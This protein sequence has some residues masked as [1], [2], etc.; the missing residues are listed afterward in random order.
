MSAAYRLLCSSLLLLAACSSEAPPPAA[1]P[2]ALDS[3]TVAELASRLVE[4]MGGRAAVDGAATIVRQGTGTRTRMGQIAATGGDDPMGELAGITETIDLANGRAAMDYDVISGGFM[5]HRTEVLTMHEGQPIG[6]ET[7]PGRPNIAVSPNGIFSWGTQNSPAW[8]LKRNVISIALAAAAAPNEQPAEE[9]IFNGSTSLYGRVGLV[10]G[11]EIGL[12]FDPDTGLL[13]GYTALDTEVLL[14][15]V[16]AEY[17]LADWR[18]AGALVLPHRMTIRKDNAPYS[19]VSYS[20][21]AVNPGGANAVFAIPADAVAQAD[22]VVA[23]AGGW[24]PLQ[25]NN[26]ANGVY[27]AVGYSHHSMVVEFPSFVA[28]IEAPYT[29]AHSQT[30]V[31]L[32]DNEIGKPVRYVVPTHP[33]YDHTGGIRGLAAIGAAVVV[34]EGH[35]GELRSIVESPHSNPPDGLA[36]IERSGGEVGTLEV[37]SS[38]TT[39][40]E[41]GR[42]LQLHAVA[43]I[44]HVNPMT[45]AVV[46]DVGVLFQSDLYFG[47]PS[48]DATALHAAVSELGLELELIVGGHGGVLPYSGLVTAVD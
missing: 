39:I 41:G 13:D 4:A 17:L 20:S 46:P 36:S 27:H 38:M 45:L 30:L 31:R 28:V 11:E 37:F 1:E 23:T 42:T 32:I 16:N 3:P 5:Q 14:G 7:G 2:A 33:H 44:P 12:Y 15:D 21:I 40:E 6:W 22:Q 9:R 47:G 18:P 19:S 8:L 29:E 25:W 48:P 10:S 35:E 43:T 26:V 34:A 24:A